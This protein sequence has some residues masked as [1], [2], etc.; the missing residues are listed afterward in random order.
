MLGRGKN[1]QSD[2]PKWMGK[3]LS[4]SPCWVLRVEGGCDYTMTGARGLVHIKHSLICIVG[5]FARKEALLR[6]KLEAQNED[7]PT[8]DYEE[9]ELPSDRYVSHKF[10]GV[11]SS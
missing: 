11:C 3:S 9:Q 6:L 4:E 7:K 8:H 2:T 1:C 5:Q 10:K